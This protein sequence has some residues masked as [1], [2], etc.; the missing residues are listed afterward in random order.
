MATGAALSARAATRLRLLI[1]T[2]ADWAM[3]YLLIDAVG[4][5]PLDA[6]PLDWFQRAPQ[7][8]SMICRCGSDGRASS[9]ASWSLLSGANGVAKSKTPMGL[10]RAYCGRPNGPRNKPRREFLGGGRH[11]KSDLGDVLWR[12]HF[13]QRVQQPVHFV[14][15]VFLR[16]LESFKKLLRVCHVIP[17]SGEGANDPLLGV[18]HDVA[19]VDLPLGVCQASQQVRSVHGSD[20]PCK[21]KLTMSANT[22]QDRA[23]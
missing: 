18:D 8:R 19:M 1:G 11:T 7:E 14:K 5:D 6:F 15:T 23:I 16:L 20:P 2:E 17:A 12:R 10:Y 22:S 13:V 3:M 4:D 9:S 21:P